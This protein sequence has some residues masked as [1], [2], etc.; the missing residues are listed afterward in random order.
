MLVIDLSIRKIARCT[1]VFL[2]HC[3][4]RE[5]LHIKSLVTT[6][7]AHFCNLCIPSI[8]YYLTATR[9]GIVAILKELTPRF[10]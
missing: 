6:T 10:H 9:F 3:S 8:T 2:L 5:L 7:N 1:G 4:F